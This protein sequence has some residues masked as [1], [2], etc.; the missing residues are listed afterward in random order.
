MSDGDGLLLL[1]FR[2]DRVREILAALLDP[3]FAGFERGARSPVRGRAR[4]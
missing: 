4:A 1:N 3:E 2:A